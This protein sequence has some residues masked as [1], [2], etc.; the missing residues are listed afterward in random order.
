M[1]CCIHAP[2]LNFAHG[3]VVLIRRSGGE[4]SKVLLGVDLSAYVY[5]YMFVFLYV[6]MFKEGRYQYDAHGR[7]W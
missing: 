5:V 6:Y 4:R 7:C 3:I 2:A 1:C